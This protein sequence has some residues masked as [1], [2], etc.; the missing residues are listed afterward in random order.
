MKKS[1]TYATRCTCGWRSRRRI[2]PDAAV[3]HGDDHVARVANDGAMHCTL[4]DRV[5]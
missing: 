1:V 3:R 5:W 4:L 2:D